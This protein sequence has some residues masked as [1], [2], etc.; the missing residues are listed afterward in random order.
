MNVVYGLIVVILAFIIYGAISRKKVYS[1]VDQLEA[2][3]IQIMNKPVSDEIAKIKGLN[4]SGE[5]EEKFESWRNEWDEI[6]TLHLPDIEEKLFDVEESANKYKFVK[7][8]KLADNISAELTNIE[9]KINLITDEINFLIHSEEQNRTQIEEVRT[10]YQDFKEYWST[11]KDSLGC[12]APFF[13]K[14][15]KKIGDGFKQFETA[16]QSGNYFEASEILRMMSEQM[17]EDQEKMVDV[18]RILIEIESEIPAQ[19]DEI[20]QGMMDMEGQGYDLKHFPFKHDLHLLKKK[21]NNLLSIIEEGNISSVLIPIEE[22]HKEIEQIYEAL[23][24]EVL[25]KQEVEYEL[26]RLAE[27]TYQI[28]LK[29]KE[30]KEEVEIVKL[31]YRISSD[32]LKTHLKLEKQIKDLSYKV[33]V[34]EEIIV[35]ETQSYTSIH[36]MIRELIEEFKEK[37]EALDNCIETLN[38]L[39]KEELKAKETLKQLKAKI[40]QGKRLIKQSN[41]PGLPES[42]IFQVEEAEQSLSQARTKLDE[43]PIVMEE[44]N[45]SMDKALQSVNGIFDKVTS[46]I[47]QAMMAE[48]VIQYGNRFRSKY[49]FVHE[50]LL[51][52]EEAF[53]HYDYEVALDISL[54]AITQIDPNALDHVNSYLLE[55]V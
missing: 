4:M 26:P 11:N 9:N 43:I 6:L 3:K 14:E 8:K 49:S 5:T 21:L 17:Q 46:T 15:I 27:N 28:G 51:I 35:N 19:L 34:I 13:E 18:P 23:E 44:V 54:K 41:I 52:A 33:K 40:I 10:K 12:A 16:T 1:K 25:S 55:K 50:E 30:L 48:K 47:E 36:L 24:Q 37:D 42:L 7:A 45:Q 2:W 53:R 38:A 22:I 39:R 31:S 20:T 32:E 29:F